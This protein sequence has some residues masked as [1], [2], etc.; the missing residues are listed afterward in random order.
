MKP[1]TYDGIGYRRRPARTVRVG[2]VEIGSE[3]P[4]RVQSM[5]TPS[6]KDT[7]ATVDQIERLIDSK[8]YIELRVRVKKG[9]Q[10]DPRFLEELGL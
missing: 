5:T 1:W 3:H 2:D 8:V 9:W 4:I 7:L 6:T 10:N